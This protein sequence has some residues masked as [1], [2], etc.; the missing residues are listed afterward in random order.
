MILYKPGTNISKY[1]IELYK[2]A[3][4]KSI[5]R[6]I[7][8]LDVWIICN[9]NVWFHS[10]LTIYYIEYPLCKILNHNVYY[11]KVL[12]IEKQ[13]WCWTHSKQIFYTKT[14][15]SWPQIIYL[16]HFRRQKKD[17]SPWNGANITIYIWQTVLHK[18]VCFL[19]K[20]FCCLCNPGYIF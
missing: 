18:T 10:W 12:H 8:L 7:I 5:R 13:R 4:I 14:T 15:A 11:E 3:K 20:I 9:M 19:E 1:I 16:L 6:C 2:Y 17:P